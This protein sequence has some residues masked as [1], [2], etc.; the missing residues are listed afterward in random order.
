MSG[1]SF[2]YMYE[3]IKETYFDEWQDVEMNDLLNDLC[4]VLH[5]LEWWQSGDYSEDDYRDAVK[6]FKAKWL[7]GYSGKEDENDARIERAKTHILVA[8]KNELDRM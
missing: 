6:T 2:N 3:R 4:I 1:G 5:D 8:V 7:S